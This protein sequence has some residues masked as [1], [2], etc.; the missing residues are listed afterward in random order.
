M[1]P[2]D[3]Q[4]AFQVSH[5]VAIMVSSQSVASSKGTARE[6]SVS[7]LLLAGSDSQGLLG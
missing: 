1:A 3:P 4:L 6:E 7:T 5:K 2:S